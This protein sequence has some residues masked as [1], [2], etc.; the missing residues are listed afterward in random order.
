[1]RN[2]RNMYIRCPDAAGADGR[3]RTSHHRRGCTTWYHSSPHSVRPVPALSHRQQWANSEPIMSDH[4]HV[5]EPAHAD[6]ARPRSGWCAK[7]GEGM[8]VV[9]AGRTSLQ[10]IAQI[11]RDP[12]YPRSGKS[13]LR[14]FPAVANSFRSLFSFSFCLFPPLKNRSI[15][16]DADKPYSDQRF[17]QMRS[18]T[19]DDQPR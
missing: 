8:I 6:R 11:T 19:T 14:S 3:K 17:A 4:C 10:V 2:V 7:G 13:T 1:M 18:Q 12:S 9:V 5:P 15:P 16:R